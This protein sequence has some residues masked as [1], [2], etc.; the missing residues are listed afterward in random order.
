MNGLL[1]GITFGI[2]FLIVEIIVNVLIGYNISWKIVCAFMLLYIIIFASIGIGLGIV[3]FCLNKCRQSRLKTMYQYIQYL[4]IILGIIIIFSIGWEFSYVFEGIFLSTLSYV[5]IALFLVGGIVIYRFISRR[6]DNQRNKFLAI[7]FSIIIAMSGLLII[8][9]KVNVEILGDLFSTKSIMWN[10]MIIAGSIISW[11]LLYQVIFRVL[12]IRKKLS[13]KLIGTFLLLIFVVPGIYAYINT[14][15]KE[16]IVPKSLKKNFP[17]I[18]LINIDTLRADHLECYGYERITAPNITK[19]AKE[20]VLFR[21][22]ISQADWTIPSVASLLTSLYPSQHMV[23]AFGTAVP[24]YRLHNSLI[25]LAEVLKE[26]GYITAGFIANPV[27]TKELG[28]AQGFNSYKVVL[29]KN[30]F[31]YLL[32]PIFYHEEYLFHNLG[33]KI[34]KWIFNSH[35]SFDKIIPNTKALFEIV[36]PW[37]EEHK[38]DTFFL[39][40]HPMDP[41]DPYNPPKSYEKM[42]SG[43]YTGRRYTFDDLIKLKKNIPQDGLQNI[44]DRYD[45]EIRFLDDQIGELINKL[46]KINLLDKTLLIITSDHGEAFLEH[47]DVGH[48]NSLFEYLIRVPLIIRFPKLIKEPAIINHQVAIID[49]MPTILDALDI[50]IPKQCQGKS[51]LPLLLQKSKTHKEFIFSEKV[52]SYVSVRTEN[53]KYIFIEKSMEEHLGSSKLAH[54]EKESLYDL[55]NDP[56]ELHNVYQQNEKIVG[57]LKEVIITHQKEIERRKV[58]CLEE[59]TIDKELESR[60]KALGYIQ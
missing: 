24:K 16:N 47:D 57:I 36:Y 13:W 3:R 51:F 58:K 20:G 6:Y 41:H 44:I 21:N 53:Y 37:L 55:K 17:N 25:T 42:Y 54:I 9:M 50:I 43:N 12:E 11:V 2:C 49:I 23:D 1:S 52:K 14:Q 39:Y 26:K 60:F 10:A 31:G 5:I 27:L 32:Y 8:E 7:N 18:I 56:N 38:N 33:K 34:I 45:G 48:G 15:E 40:L 35:F 29:Q 22:A 19:L 46:I 59:A 30:L 4:W 28:F